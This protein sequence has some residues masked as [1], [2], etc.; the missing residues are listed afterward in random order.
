MAISSECTMKNHCSECKLHDCECTCHTPP[1]PDYEALDEL[2][3]RDDDTCSN[4]DCEH[5]RDMHDE[6]VGLC[7]EC[8]CQ[9]FM[10]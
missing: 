3:K 5:R 10:E 8:K 1:I 9:R 2:L 7:S 6:K 4:T